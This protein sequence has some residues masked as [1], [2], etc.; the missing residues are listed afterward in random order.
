MSH[1]G[2]RFG[3][4]CDGKNAEKRKRK[5]RGLNGNSTF[6]K[7]VQSMLNMRLWRGMINPAKQTGVACAPVP[8]NL[9]STRSSRTDELCDL[10][11]IDLDQNLRDP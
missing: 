7:R 10:D 5:G 8:H 3:R 11:L 9:G 6:R 4:L 1:F 2:L